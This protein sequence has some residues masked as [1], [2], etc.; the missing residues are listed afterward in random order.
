MYRIFFTPQNCWYA[1]PPSY[2]RDR[3]EMTG[4]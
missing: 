4:S 1:G 3:A 2:R